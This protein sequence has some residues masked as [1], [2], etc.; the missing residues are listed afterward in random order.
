MESGRIMYCAMPESLSNN[1]NLGYGSTSMLTCF[2]AHEFL[3]ET[4]VY[5]WLFYTTSEKNTMLNLQLGCRRFRPCTLHAIECYPRR[6]WWATFFLLLGSHFCNWHK[7]SF[8]TCMDSLMFAEHLT[9]TLGQRYSSNSLHFHAKRVQWIGPFMF[10]VVWTHLRPHH[11][12][13]TS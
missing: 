2:Q 3:M 11:V 7:V 10:D 5:E 1:T 4:Q 6:K 8:R 13:I 9:D 12:S